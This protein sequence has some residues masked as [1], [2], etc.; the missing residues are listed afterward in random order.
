VVNLLKELSKTGYGRK[1]SIGKGQFSV[2]EIKEF[3]FSPIQNANGFVT[4]S[5]FCPTEDDPTEGLYKTF[6]KYGKLGEEFTFCGNPF[7]RP[8]LMI[9][10]GSVFKIG[11]QPKEF[12]GRIVPNIAPA[13]ESEVVQYAYAFTVPIR[14]LE[15]SR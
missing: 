13:K 15:T 4:L 5:N 9:R 8:L 3:N 10:T 7:K 11:S 2:K 12:Y 1:K 14:Y 6:I